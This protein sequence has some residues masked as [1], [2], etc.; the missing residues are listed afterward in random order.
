M[1]FMT[2]KKIKKVYAIP[3]DE[4]SWYEREKELDEKTKK[5]LQYQTEEEIPKTKKSF[6]QYEREFQLYIKEFCSTKH[7]ALNTNIMIYYEKMFDVETYFLTL[8]KNHNNWLVEIDMRWFYVLDKDNQFFFK[9]F[10]FLIYELNDNLLI[11]YKQKYKQKIFN[12]NNFLDSFDVYVSNYKPFKSKFVGDY[13]FRCVYDQHTILE[14]LL[15]YYVQMEVDLMGFIETYQTSFYDDLIKETFFINSFYLTLTS[16]ITKIN[17][18]LQFSFIKTNHKSFKS[19]KKAQLELIDQSIQLQNYY[20]T[21]TKKNNEWA[22]VSKYQK[23]MIALKNQKQKTLK[24]W[25]TNIPEWDLAVSF[26]FLEDNI[27]KNTLYLFVQFAMIYHIKVN[28]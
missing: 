16:Y 12:N 10:L 9:C 14:E 18:F 13:R 19:I 4:K 11:F 8:I 2:N 26:S 3:A 24:Q 1:F 28:K 20:A 21:Q 25:S 22:D 23:K 7:I 27:F 5:S 17:T 6:N 15:A